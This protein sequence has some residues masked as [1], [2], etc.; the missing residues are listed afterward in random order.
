VNF[1]TASSAGTTKQNRSR[2]KR[3]FPDSLASRGPLFRGTNLSSGWVPA[4]RREDVN[5][6]A[7]P[8]DPHLIFSHALRNCAATWPNTGCSRPISQSRPCWT[9]LD[10]ARAE[11]VSEQLSADNGKLSV[12]LLSLAPLRGSSTN[13][14]Q[15]SLIGS[16]ANSGCHPSPLFSCQPCAHARAELKENGEFSPLRAYDRISSITP[17]VVRSAMKLCPD[18]IQLSWRV[19]KN[20][21]GDIRYEHCG[22]EPRDP[23]RGKFGHSAQQRRQ[24]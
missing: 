5:W 14:I 4:F 3:Q 15:S 7:S 6:F 23:H 13:A 9:G 16:S 22:C 11:V 21:S 10:G 1:L 20:Q 8:R 24:R 17:D 12:N 19:L 18:C 2:S